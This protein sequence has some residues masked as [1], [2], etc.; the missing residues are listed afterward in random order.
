MTIK[1]KSVSMLRDGPDDFELALLPASDEADPKAPAL[2]ADL[3]QAEQAIRA[4]GYNPAV[5][6]GI[7]KSLTA[8]GSWLLG[9]FVFKAAAGGAGITFV[10]KALT[11]MMVEWLKGRAG[12]RV[13]IKVGDIE[14]EAATVKQAETLIER[15]RTIKAEQDRQP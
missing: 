14:V 13:R 2:Q 12:R 15:A 6:T 3:Q 8:V 7:Q 11:P 4:Q 1:V 5:G 9:T 10:G